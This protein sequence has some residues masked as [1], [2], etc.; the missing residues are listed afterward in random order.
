M[1]SPLV[2]RVLRVPV[3]STGEQSRRT[4]TKLVAA[5]IVFPLERCVCRIRRCK[6]HSEAFNIDL[7]RSSWIDV[8]WHVAPYRSKKTH[9]GAHLESVRQGCG[10]VEFYPVVVRGADIGGQI[11]DLFPRQLLEQI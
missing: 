6:W 1:I 3:G 2:S 8:I 9:S 7:L 10:Y 11:D 5:E 4:R